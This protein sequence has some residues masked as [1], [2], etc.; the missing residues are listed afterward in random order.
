MYQISEHFSQAAVH[1]HGAAVLTLQTLWLRNIRTPEC[2][3]RLCFHVGCNG[4]RRQWRRHKLGY[5]LHPRLFP[6]SQCDVAAPPERPA[7]RRSAAPRGL[8]MQLM[9][10]I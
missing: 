4:E 2:P 10:R 5:G 9:T 3:V 8:D 7:A 1:T 6:R